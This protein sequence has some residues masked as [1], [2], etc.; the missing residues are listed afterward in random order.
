MKIGG[1]FWFVED[2]K[3][4]LF[5]YTTNFKKKILFFSSCHFICGILIDDTLNWW[6]IPCQ[7]KKTIIAYIRLY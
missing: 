5:F 3:V 2:S 6:M 7:M 4:Y 1:Q